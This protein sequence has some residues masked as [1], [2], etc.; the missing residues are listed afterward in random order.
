MTETTPGRLVVTERIAA[1]REVVFR[2]FTD[3]E[4]YRA[5]MGA[6]TDFDA[7]PGGIYRVH[8]GE[9]RTARGEFVVVE[10][11]SRVVF[12]WGWEGQREVPSGS[13]RVEVTLTEQAGETVVTLVH[14]GL[15]DRDAVEQHRAGWDLYLGRLAVAAV[16]GD[17]GPDPNA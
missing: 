5:W 3:P 2:Y 10:P 16:G 4:R 15:P 7:R 9:G 8:M 11:P 13:S 17:P 14:S 6:R 12:T 1:P